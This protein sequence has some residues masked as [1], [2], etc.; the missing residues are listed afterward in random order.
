MGACL[1]RS[2]DSEIHMDGLSPV[3]LKIYRSE[4]R[5]NLHRIPYDFYRS[6]IKRFGYMCDLSEKHLKMISHEILLDYKEMKQ[7]EMSP[8][9]LTYLSEEFRSA[10]RRHDVKKLLRLGWL[11]CKHES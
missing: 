7:N 5:L 2:K 3:E 11:M 4:C 10:D 1:D 9:A 6:S 8:F